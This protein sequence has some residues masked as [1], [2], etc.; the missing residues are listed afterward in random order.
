[1]AQRFEMKL[2]LALEAKSISSIRWN[3]LPGL[4]ATELVGRTG[5]PNVSPEVN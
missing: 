5:A 3:A 2:V 1:M 4:T